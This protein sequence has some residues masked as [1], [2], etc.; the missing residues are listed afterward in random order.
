MNNFKI[1]ILARIFLGYVLIILVLSGLIFFFSFRVTRQHYLKSLASDMVNLGAV[2]RTEIAPLLE[3]SEFDRMDSLVKTLGEEAHTR[4]TVVA[5]DGTVL[6]DSQRDPALMENH[7][8]RPEISKALKGFRARALRYSTTFQEEMLYV[9]LPVQVDEELG[10][11][12]RMSLYLKDINILLKTLVEN[13]LLPFGALIVAASLVA[14]LLISRALAR[15]IMELA[16][17]SRKVADGDFDATVTFRMNG[18]MKDLQDSFNLMTGRIKALVSQLTGQ[19]DYL[20]RIIASIGEGLVV[21][22]RNGIIRMANSAF[23]ATAGAEKA[24]GRSYREVIPEASLREF[25]RECLENHAA[26]TGEVH[27]GDKECVASASFA[28]PEEELVVVLHDV[29]ESRRLER[30]QRDFLVNV[31]HELKTPLTAI[32]GFA[33]T[34]A[35]AEGEQQYL[36]VIKRHTDRL[37]AIVNNLLLLARLEDKECRLELSEVDVAGIVRDV[38]RL[39]KSRLEEKKITA[40]IY[41]QD[42][43]PRVAADRLEMEQALVNLIDN[44]VKYTEQGKIEIKLTGNDDRIRIVIE[45]TGIGIPASHL[46]RVWERFYVVDK[47]RSR[48]LGGAGLGLSIVRRIVLLHRGTIHIESKPGTGT[49]VILTLPV[50]SV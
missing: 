29:S 12:V 8:D 36:E 42:D 33:E 50:S 34:I 25:I 49:R 31:S 9:A 7:A 26:G 20:D 37:I 40:Q 23:Q 13:T 19:K 27:F 5:L 17:A 28:G 30:A 48:K 46:A 15:P 22:D 3:I 43:L 6:A 35:P 47:S 10:G 11:V 21:V 44:A 18:E 14:A 24:V 32:K 4:I 39:F 1:S 16:E 41:A 38:V 45:D 2:I